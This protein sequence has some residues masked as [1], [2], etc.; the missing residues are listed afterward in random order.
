[1]SDLK[2]YLQ[3]RIAALIFQKECYV[4]MNT[5]ESAQKVL[6]VSVELKTCEM[7]LEAITKCLS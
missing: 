3:T 5:K 7:Q 6:Y 1:M 4:R 2:L